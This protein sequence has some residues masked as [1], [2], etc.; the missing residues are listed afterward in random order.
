M[1]YVIIWKYR[2][3]PEF[4]E[5]FAEA[6]GPTGAGVAFFRGGSGYIRTDLIEGE[7]PD[8]FATLDWWESE[9]HYT[10]FAE[11]NRERYAEID[12]GFDPWTEIEERVGAGSTA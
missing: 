10:T 1:A 9:S 8:T 6:Y 12:R 5:R 4:V 2:V 11:A 7:Q 3:K